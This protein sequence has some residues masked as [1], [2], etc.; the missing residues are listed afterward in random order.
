MWGWRDLWG[1]TPKRL[2]KKKKAEETDWLIREAKKRMEADLG[3]A[4]KAQ[5]AVGT[6]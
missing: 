1:Q 5:S 3:G 6:V 2:R 4:M